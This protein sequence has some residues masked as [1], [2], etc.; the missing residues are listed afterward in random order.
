MFYTTKS[1]SLMYYQE[2]CG[3]VVLRLSAAPLPHCFLALGLKIEEAI[4]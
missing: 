4:L 1:Q 2:F 3:V